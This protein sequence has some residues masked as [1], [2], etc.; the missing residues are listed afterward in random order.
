MPGP[1]VALIPLLARLAPALIGGGGAAATAGAAGGEAAATM[2][3]MSRIASVVSGIRGATSG[4]T[5]KKPQQQQPQGW[6]FTS[7]TDPGS[8]SGSTI[9]PPPLPP[10]KP[11]PISDTMPALK[12]ASVV[13][14]LLAMPAA[15]AGAIKGIEKLGEASVEGYRDVAK[16]HGGLAIMFAQMDRQNLILGARYAAATGTSATAAGGSLMSLKQEMAPLENLAGTLKNI[17]VIALIDTAR[18]LVFT[19]KALNPW[20]EPM[21]RFCAWVESL[22]GTPKLPLV[23]LLERMAQD[24]LTTRIK[25][26]RPGGPG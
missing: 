6:S 16:F 20:L 5:E 24:A 9:L 3:T 11:D 2:G 12:M 21:A 1:L 7:Q 19:I 17:G 25:N 13:S 26:R 10:R 15:I 18:L 8:P 22:G 14:G 23:G 4:A